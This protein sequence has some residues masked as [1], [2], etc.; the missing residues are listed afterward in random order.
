[1]TKAIDFTRGPVYNPL[2]RFAVPI[3]GAL[4]LQALYGG[5]DLLIVG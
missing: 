3:L 1:M 2:V 4:F 5:I